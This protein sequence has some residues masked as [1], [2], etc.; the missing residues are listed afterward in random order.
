MKKKTLESR[1]MSVT[2]TVGM[3]QIVFWVMLNKEIL[4]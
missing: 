1:G 4:H 3:G 2:C